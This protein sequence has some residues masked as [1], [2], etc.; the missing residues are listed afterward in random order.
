MTAIHVKSDQDQPDVLLRGTENGDAMVVDGNLIPLG[1]DKI[2]GLT[3]AKG[4][5]Q[6][7]GAAIPTGARIV[8]IQVEGQN[9][10]WRDDASDP[11]AAE[12]LQ[13]KTTSD[14]FWYVGTLTAIKFIEVTPTAT[15]YVAFYK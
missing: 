7:V 13:I 4:L 12:G 5:A 8:L 11:T 15:L 14:G 2:T 9:V 1:Y 6:G 3:T 10:R